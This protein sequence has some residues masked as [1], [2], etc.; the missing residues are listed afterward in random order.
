MGAS[1]GADFGNI[2]IHALL[3]E[4]D[5]T[6]QFVSI[7]TSYFY[8]RSPCGERRRNG[9]NIKRSH[10]ISIH[11]LLAE[12]D[13]WV[14]RKVPILGIF[15]STLSLRRA[16][17]VL[18]GSKSSIE[19]FYPRSPCGE[20]RQWRRSVK[21]FR[22]FYPRSPCGERL[23]RKSSAYSALKI[24]IHALLAESDRRP[25]FYY[26]TEWNFYPRSPCGERRV[27]TPDS[28]RRRRISIHA[29]LAE[30]DR[31]T[32]CCWTVAR[33]FYPRSPCGERRRGAGNPA[34][35]TVHFYPRSP[36]GERRTTLCCWTVARYFYPRSPCGERQGRAERLESQGI[37]SI[38][39]LLA[40][41]DTE[42]S[43]CLDSNELFLS[44]LS[45]R[46]ATSTATSL[47]CGCFV[48]LS[49]LSL[50]RATIRTRIRIAS[51]FYFYPRSPCGERPFG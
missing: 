5:R 48:F 41:S 39:A 7:P 4:S 34:G 16:T 30:S 40:E 11:A 37:I 45:L 42:G 49:T 26:R 2:S 29:L 28:A 25:I 36:C 1:Q 9:Q 20:R 31:T 27:W 50:R 47:F 35:G 6:G 38:H 23:G 43:I 21:L 32:L 44:T 15:L 19:D 10:K 3:A 17:R 51:N 46:R 18:D 33:Y 22:H 12:S 14:L 8:P 24:S 13:L